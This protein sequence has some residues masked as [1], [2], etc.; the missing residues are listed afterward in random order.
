MPPEAKIVFKGILFDVYQ[1]EQEMFD[2]SRMTFERLHRK[3]SVTILPVTV[4]GHI[5]ICEEEQP[6]R[7]T[8]F[9]T[10]GGQVD[11]S[12][13][14]P[15]IAAERELREETG[16]AGEFELWMENHPYGNKIDW[17]VHTYIARNCR[18][19]ADPHL[20]AGERIK[21]QLVDFDT[22]V[23][24]VLNNE[25]FRNVEMTIAVMNAMRKDGGLDELK[26]LLLG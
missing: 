9:S 10:P 2:G 25:N 5:M 7:G 21:P 23:D 17:T 18:K 13:A 24:T 20:D 26:K 12:D 1:W 8:F 22:F 6:F 3:P 16:Y 19:V 11:A 14:S 15:Q 4:D